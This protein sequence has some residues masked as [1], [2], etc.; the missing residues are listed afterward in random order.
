MDHPGLMASIISRILHPH[1][2]KDTDLQWG[3]EPDIAVAHRAL[4]LGWEDTSH[5]LVG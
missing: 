2:G 1:W 3:S 4:G 5:V